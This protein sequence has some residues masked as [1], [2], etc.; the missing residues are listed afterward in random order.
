M[1]Y[2]WA[3]K[4]LRLFE[5]RLQTHISRRTEILLKNQ[6]YWIWTKYVK[7]CMGFFY[8]V[9][10]VNFGKKLY[11]DQRNAQVCY[12][13]YLSIYFCLTCCGWAGIA[14]SVWRL[15][16][17]WRIRGS[18]PG[19][20]EIFRTRPDRPWGPHNL[21]YNGYRAFPGGKAA[22]AWCWPPTPF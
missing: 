1:G 14:Q 22:G 21:L 8:V 9:R 13:L 18:N 16:T 15:A 3:F 5:L 19:G 20:D 4:G 17:G 7:M 6:P 11:N 10:T 2:N 12:L